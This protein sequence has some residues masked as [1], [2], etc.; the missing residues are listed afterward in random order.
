VETARLADHNAAIVVAIRFLGAGSVRGR[1]ARESTA[2]LGWLFVGNSPFPP[3]YI[4][5]EPEQSE[6]EGRLEYVT[7]PH[8]FC[9][10][11][12]QTVR[13]S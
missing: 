5:G 7:I 4:F 11:Q 9:R 8:P 1:M 2:P 3:A 13:I 6:R 12:R 10:H